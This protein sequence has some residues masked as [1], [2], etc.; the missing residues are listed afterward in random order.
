MKEGMRKGGPV[1]SPHPS[2]PTLTS[3]DIGTS[4]A[5]FF[6]EVASILAIVPAILNIAPQWGGNFYRDINT[7]VKATTILACVSMGLNAF[8]FFV[9]SFLFILLAAAG[10]TDDQCPDSFPRGTLLVPALI[11]ELF[12]AAFLV[13][14]TCLSWK[15]VKV[16]RSARRMMDPVSHG[17]YTV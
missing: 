11:L 1:P 9:L 14:H 10:C 2:C 3:Q 7:R 6:A 15:V 5:F 16:C 8:V 17:M 13:G 12:F 4:G